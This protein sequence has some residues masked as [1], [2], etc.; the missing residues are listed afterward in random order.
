MVKKY[1]ALIMF[2]A[3]SVLAL[4]LIVT[5]QQNVAAF[6]ESIPFPHKVIPDSGGIIPHLHLHDHLHGFP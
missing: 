2:A 5:Q 3:I 6:S 1:L 4:P